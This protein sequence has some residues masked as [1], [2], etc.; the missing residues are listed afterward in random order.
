MATRLLPILALLPLAA[1]T[2]A[3]S[4]STKKGAA[5][6]AW[7]S[8]EPECRE[9]LENNRTAAAMRC[10]EGHFWEARE[11]GRRAGDWHTTL[12]KLRHDAE[13]FTWLEQEGKVKPEVKKLFRG[14]FQ[15]ARQKHDNP[16]K[17][18]ELAFKEQTD[19]RKLWQ[20]ANNKAVYWDPA[21]KETPARILRA[22][23][24][25]LQGLEDSFRSA[26]R[27]VSD[28]FLADGTLKKLKRFLQASTFYF[29]PR[30]GYH[31]LALMEDG[32]ASPLLGQVVDALRSALPGVLGP[33][34]GIKVWKAD[35]SALAREKA[36]QPELS[37]D[38]AVS[39]LLW[40]VPSSALNGSASNALFLFQ[41]GNESEEPVARISYATNRAVI[42]GR[43]LQATWRGP[44]WKPGFL[45]RGLHL[46]FSFG[47]AQEECAA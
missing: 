29:Y 16:D 1:A 17:V 10:L 20:Q 45:Q 6:R 42:W 37:E 26:G 23:P 4:A 15:S 34:S 21:G 43:H 22:K 27:A 13:M 18:F 19:D 25:A 36:D 41:R 30:K 40:L 3:C 8:I 47:W 9:K 5:G 35:N 44:S 32:L 39:V 2:T 31:L 7:D 28:K 14:V 33:L 38:A 24:A 11:P 12:R 46:L